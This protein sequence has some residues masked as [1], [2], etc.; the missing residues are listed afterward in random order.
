MW[1]VPYHVTYPVQDT[2]PVA[3]ESRSIERPHKQTPLVNWH[4]LQFIVGGTAYMGDASGEP[5]PP[6]NTPVP[7]IDRMLGGDRPNYAGLTRGAATPF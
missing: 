3:F 2:A 5:P 6:W 1:D 4:D 7:V